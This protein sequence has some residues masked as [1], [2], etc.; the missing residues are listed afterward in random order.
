MVVGENQKFAAA[1]II[2]NF[3]HLRSWCKVKNI[4]YSLNE[5][6]IQL[7]RIK[8]RIKNEITEINK[9]LGSSEKIS[10]FELMAYEWSVDTGELSAALKIRR[11]FVFKK[12][13]KEIERL[14]N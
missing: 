1:L 14:F 10:N 13:N 6:M 4:E 8:D 12:Y 5:E 11:H 7:P 3:G 9:G 2:P